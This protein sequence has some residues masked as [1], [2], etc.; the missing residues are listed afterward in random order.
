MGE[1][2]TQALIMLLGGFIV[3]FCVLILLIIIVKLYSKIVSSVQNAAGNKKAT[4]Q[5]QEDAPV[6]T[7]QPVTVSSSSE[8]ADD[9]EIPGEIIAVI[10]AAVDAVYGSQPHRVRSVKRSHSR[11]AWGRAGV[12]ENTKPF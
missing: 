6:S 12:A 1:N 7:A 11:S 9:G 10:A 5:A 8:P 3:V 2:M 4:P